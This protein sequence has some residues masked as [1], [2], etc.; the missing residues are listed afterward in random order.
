MIIAREEITEMFGHYEQK[1]RDA[2][3]LILFET[4]VNGDASA[5]IMDGDASH[6]YRVVYRATDS[7]ETLGVVFCHT[8][9]EAKRHADNFTGINQ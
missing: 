3:I 4:V 1:L 5:L 7:N 9:L 6:S 8:Y 2:Q